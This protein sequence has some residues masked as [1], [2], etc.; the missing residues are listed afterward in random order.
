MTN[1]NWDKLRQHAETCCLNGNPHLSL[2]NESDHQNGHKLTDHT[3]DR[4]HHAADKFSFKQENHGD[5][6]REVLSSF[7]SQVS[8]GQIENLTPLQHILAPTTCAAPVGPEAPL[9]NVGCTAAGHNDGTGLP[10]TMQYQYTMKAPANEALP[11]RQSTPVSSFGDLA[12]LRVN[13]TTTVDKSQ[14]FNSQA[15]MPSHGI[16][17]SSLMGH[18]WNE[19]VPPFGASMSIFQNDGATAWQQSQYTYCGYT[20]EPP[21]NESV[22]LALYRSTSIDCSFPP[23]HNSITTTDKPAP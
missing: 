18:T 17:S 14:D 3:A 13:A 6:I 21:A 9:A 11:P 5:A 22:P 1:G 10:Y 8:K 2:D 19:N 4:V 15:T 23:G 12:P 16:G 20:M 7:P